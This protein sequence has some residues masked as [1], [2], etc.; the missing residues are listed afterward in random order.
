MVAV[1]PPKPDALAGRLLALVDA[2]MPPVRGA[3]E[4]LGVERGLRYDALTQAPRSDVLEQWLAWLDLPEAEAE[5]LRA[6]ERELHPPKKQGQPCGCGCGAITMPGKAFVRGHHMKV[7]EKVVAYQEAGVIMK[8]AV[9]EMVCQRD[10]CEIVF[11]YN[12]KKPRTFCSQSCAKQSRVSRVA[13]NQKTA[14]GKFMYAAWLEY[15]RDRKEAYLSAFAAECGISRHEL[16]DVLHDR[17]PV[18]STYQALRARCGSALP[19]VVTESER[20]GKHIMAQAKEHHP[21]PGTPA[22]QHRE[23]RRLE[24]KAAN[25]AANDGEVYRHPA[26]TQRRQQG[27]AFDRILRL[28][29]TNPGVHA[30]SDVGRAQASLF[31]HLRKHQRD[32]GTTRPKVGVIREWCLSLAV[33]VEVDGKRV[34]EIWE[35]LLKKRGLL[36]KAGATANEV[37]HDFIEAFIERWPKGPAGG[38]RKNLW[39]ACEAAAAMER[40]RVPSSGLKL[41]Y[42]Q[43]RRDYCSRLTGGKGQ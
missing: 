3:K 12:P 2:K 10:G 15:K 39:P 26:D 37:L 18:L 24:T 14:L 20:R 22:M 9:V 5:E 29:G 6:L 1:A 31:G 8:A 32:N 34:W 28:P 40:F 16:D 13:R 38:P 4:R 35:P 27:E 42:K 23:A 41:W 25:K 11:P 36:S 17:A 7:P 33:E 21:R 19:V 30:A 43:H